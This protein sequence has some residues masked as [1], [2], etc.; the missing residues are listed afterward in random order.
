MV[1]AINYQLILNQLLPLTL[2]FGLWTLD[3]LYG[4]QN[5]LQSRLILKL[6][7]VRRIR[8]T[9]VDHKKI[10][11]FAKRS[12][13]VGVIFGRVLQRGDFGF[14]EIDADGMFGPAPKRA[15]LRQLLRD[16]FGA[17]V[18]ESHAI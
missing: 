12:E 8:R 11:V 9:D 16:S 17:G 14:A 5:L 6:P 13:R 1:L 15:P 7:Q 10:R 3:F 2:D 18:V 4:C